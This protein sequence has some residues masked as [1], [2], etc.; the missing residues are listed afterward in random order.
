VGCSNTCT[1]SSFAVSAVSARSVSK[2]IGPSAS[3]FSVDT[4]VAIGTITY[5]SVKLGC[6]GNVISPVAG[7]AGVSSNP[8]SSRNFK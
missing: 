7:R 2:M 5:G 8:T 3:G 6:T 1:A 4:W